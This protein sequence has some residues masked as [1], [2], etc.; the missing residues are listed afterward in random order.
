MRVP[1]SWLR[2]VVNVGAPD[3]D[4]DPAELEQTLVRIGHEVEE[5]ATLGPVTGPLTV[6]RVT[7]IE[8]LTG[9]KKPIRFCHVDI[10][11]GTD[12]EIVC[13]ATNFAVGDLIV[14][15]LPGTT[16]PGDFT[17]A[18]RKTYGRNSDGMICSAA[19]LGLGADHSGIL[20]LPPGTAD[21]GADGAAVLGLDDVIFHLAITPDRGYCMSLR[22]PCP[23]DCLRLRPGLRRPRRQRGGQAAARQRRGMAADRA[24][25]HRRAALRAAPGHRH[26]PRR[27]VAVVAAAPAAVVRHPRRPH[28][29]ST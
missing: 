10:G 2:E 25:R 13:G 27:R 20:V 12:R 3:W 9:F 26:R 6:G 11:D 4:V 14:A 19:E 24:A 17:I 15:A 28:R 21:P 22:G 5:V 16:L 29:P 23:R 7:G 18:A 8:E 1:Y